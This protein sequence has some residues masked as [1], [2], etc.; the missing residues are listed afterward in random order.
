MR[1]LRWSADGEVVQQEK[2]QGVENCLRLPQTPTRQGTLCWATFAPTETLIENDS[3]AHMI[4]FYTKNY[5]PGFRPSKNLY[6]R[7]GL[8]FLMMKWDR[9]LRCGVYYGQ[10]LLCMEVTG[11]LAMP[12]LCRKDQFR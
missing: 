11:G 5:Y 8:L 2:R 6:G 4:N 10:K 7:R 12:R 1:Y 3:V 9:V